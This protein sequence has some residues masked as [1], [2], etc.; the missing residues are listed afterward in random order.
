MVHHPLVPRHPITGHK[1]LYALG[2][3]AHGIEGMDEAEAD[4][5][6]DEL[7]DH[8]LQEKFLY[9]HRY[10]VGELVIWDTLSTMHAAVPIDFADGAENERLLWRISVRG[11]PVVYPRAA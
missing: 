6:L 10:E 2:H 8:V 4:A 5:L 7:R 9:A 3:G 1:A 11:R